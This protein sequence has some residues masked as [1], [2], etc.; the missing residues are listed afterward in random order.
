[1]PM[2]GS[3]HKT[4]EMDLLMLLMNSASVML[5]AHSS[6]QPGESLP[7]LE[8]LEGARRL[9]LLYTQA[10]LLLK[11]ISKGLCL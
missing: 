7:T 1:M 2:P 5:R 4:T 6:T 3:E 10:D 9:Q 8:T 11:F